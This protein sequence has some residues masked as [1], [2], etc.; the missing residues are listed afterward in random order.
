M[1]T[2]NSFPYNHPIRICDVPA[3]Y[4]DGND[5]PDVNACSADKHTPANFHIHSHSHPTAGPHV[6]TYRDPD[7]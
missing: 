3:A 6:Q 1:R 7:I 5:T 2:I 4:R